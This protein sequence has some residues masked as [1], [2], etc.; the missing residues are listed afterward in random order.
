MAEM[1]FVV[2]GLDGVVINAAR[3]VVGIFSG[4]L[5]SVGQALPEDRVGA[6]IDMIA[7]EVVAWPAVEFVCHILP[8][9][10]DVPLIGTLGIFR[11]VC[12]ANIPG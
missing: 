7:G 11:D 10:S 3:S 5:G 4:G 8:G 1:I 6:E 2:D 12:Q 9:E